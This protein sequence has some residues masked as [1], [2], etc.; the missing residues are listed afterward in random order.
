MGKFKPVVLLILDG[1]GLSPAW[2]GNAMAMS[3]PKCFNDYWRYYP[4]TILQA[5]S[6][7]TYGKIVGESRLGHLMIGAGRQ[8]SG[9]HNLINHEIETGKFY[10]NQILLDAISWAKKNNSDLHFLGM[11]SDGGVHSDVEH[12]IALLELARKEN[13][14]RVFVDAITDGIDSSPTDALKYIEKIQYQFNKYRIGQ[15]TSVMGRS[16]AMDR[17]EHWDKI[18]LAYEVLTNDNAP[19]ADNINQ[20]ISEN[21]RRAL[22]DN[23]ITPTKL[24]LIDGG[25]KSIKSGDA[26]IFFN[27]REDRAKSLTRVFIEP[28]FGFFFWHP[29]K[30]DN[31]Y[32]ATFSN[33]L[34]SLPAKVVFSEPH[35]AN[36]LSELISKNNLKQLKIAESEKYSHVTSFF[37]GGREEP[38]QNEERKIVSSPNVDSYDK[39]PEMSA[40]AIAK[41]CILA[42]KTNRYDLIVVN[43]ANVDMVAH[44]G[45][46]R[47]TGKAVQVLDKYIQ[48]ITE[49]NLK[50]KGVTIITADHGNAEQM[51]NLNQQI[52]RERETLH[53]VNP[54]PFILITPENKKNIIKMAMS[55]KPNS[56]D[57]ILTSKKTLA[58][59]AP[60]ILE[61]LNIQKPQE[62]TG[63]SLINQLE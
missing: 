29:N 34:H 7:T 52:S 46:I 30:L 12:L 10:S 1:W 20:V 44:T 27:F 61:I 5:L 58:D 24:K 36:S 49:T 56:L 26:V 2:G 21:Y 33:Y 13:F 62:M 32:F 55:N 15:F 4:H 35:Y 37:N 38:Y 42:I 9:M 48:E 11:I 22:L 17:D 60:T 40:K 16:Y 45:N 39:K 25:Y 8:V 19:K 18:R 43:F 3:K 57:K 53:T 59:V 6:E 28:K 41:A 54:V 31:L 50:H 63:R 14:T 23:A 51:I 47:A